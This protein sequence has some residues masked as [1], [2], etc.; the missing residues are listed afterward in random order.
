MKSL[1]LYVS[2]FESCT[3]IT[4]SWKKCVLRS[5]FMRFIKYIVYLFYSTTKTSEFLG[6]IIYFF[7]I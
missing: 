2:S 1:V 3:F 4:W 7:I 6:K 5:K